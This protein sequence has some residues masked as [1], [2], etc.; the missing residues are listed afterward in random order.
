MRADRFRTAR[1]AVIKVRPPR[2]GGPFDDW[3][4]QAAPRHLSNEP[5]PHFS[6]ILF[7]PEKPPAQA[8]CTIPADNAC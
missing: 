5:R 4:S 7:P 6:P 1:I 8:D 3:A 2:A